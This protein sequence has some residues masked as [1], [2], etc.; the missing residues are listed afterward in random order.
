MC[1]CSILERGYYKV[2]FRSVEQTA[3]GGCG[4]CL[5]RLNTCLLKMIEDNPFRVCFQPKCF[6]LFLFSSGTS[7]GFW[8]DWIFLP[9][10]ILIVTDKKALCA[11]NTVQTRNIIKITLHIVTGVTC[12]IIIT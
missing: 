9:V 1:E 3:L 7:L 11:K 6:M 8:S 10:T 4:I 5:T 2:T 12:Q